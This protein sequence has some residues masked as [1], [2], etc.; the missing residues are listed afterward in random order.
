[1]K[2]NE[3]SSKAFNF[4]T[5]RTEAPKVVRIAS[6][7]RPTKTGE[8]PADAIR[9]VIETEGWAVQEDPAL[10]ELLSDVDVA[11]QVS[12]RLN[13]LIAEV[14]LFCYELDVDETSADGAK[15]VRDAP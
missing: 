11:A 7:D 10:L 3:K 1:M 8:R 6:G 12:R 4:L 13:D 5:G 14:L 2:W 15:T 9:R